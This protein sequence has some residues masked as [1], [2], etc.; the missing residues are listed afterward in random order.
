[1]ST[2]TTNA[3]LSVVFGLALLACS[4]KE[5]GAASSGTVATGAGA[6]STTS[7][8][9]RTGSCQKLT[10]AGKCTEYALKDELSTSI[11]K[12]GCE[13]TDGQWQLTACPSEKQFANCS[14]SESKIFYYAG[15]QSADAVIQANEEFAELDCEMMSGKLAV[16]GK[17]TPTAA[18]VASGG[19]AAGSK[20]AAAAGSKPKK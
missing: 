19:K 15:T 14:T 10:K 8:S 3:V 18:P 4:K 1:M 12:G 11:Q 13:A 7:S 20:P 2:T 5:E 16:T 6:A 17:S 9:P